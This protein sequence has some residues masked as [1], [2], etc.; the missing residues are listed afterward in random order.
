M[1][2]PTPVRTSDTKKF[3]QSREWRLRVDGRMEGSVIAHG[4][5]LDVSG[6]ATGG[7]LEVAGR[8]VWRSVAMEG[9]MSV[10][11]RDL[12]AK[13]GPEHR[14]FSADKAVV[15]RSSEGETLEVPRRRLICYV[16]GG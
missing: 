12:R 6:V 15:I 3:S 16:P 14:V 7:K 2:G 13:A 11:W 10:S 1:K 9:A 8:G 4:R 5:T